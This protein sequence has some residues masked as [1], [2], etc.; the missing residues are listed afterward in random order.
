[1]AFEEAEPC[2]G[3]GTGSVRIA[4]AQHDLVAAEGVLAA[5]LRAHQPG[6][7]IATHTAVV[8]SYSLEERV[9]IVTGAS[10]GIGEATGRHL[11]ARGLH[12][13]L[14]ARRQKRLEALAAEIAAA[15]GQ[16]T[17]LEGDLAAAAAPA[18][19]VEA[20]LDRCGRLDVIVNNAASF[21]LK[22]V[23][24]VTLDEFDDHVAVNVRAP[25]FLV[26][27]ALPALRAS[28]A[29]VVVNVS[30]AAAV[31]FRRGQTV[32]GLTKAAIEHLT[33]NLAAEL[34]PDRIRVAGVRP[35]PVATEIHLAVPDPEARKRELGRL[36]PL[37]R[38]GQPEEIARWIGHLVDEDAEWVT[39]TVISVDGGRVLGPPG[40]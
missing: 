37:G 1:V 17:A 8:S 11:A 15:G 6:S 10:S 34:A 27:A 23:E 35:G 9:A 4:R 28:P 36:V 22:P 39:G 16:A 13:I 19:L 26:Q 33:M 14:V 3:A 32:Y 31:M 5:D 40:V 12:V 7:T 25:Y 18:H 30:S 20:V 29:A 2:I 38:I 24:E 21:R